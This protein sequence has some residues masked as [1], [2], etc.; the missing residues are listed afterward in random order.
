MGARASSSVDCWPF[1]LFYRFSAADFFLHANDNEEEEYFLINLEVFV[2]AILQKMHRILV[3]MDRGMH[4][5]AYHFSLAACR[6]VYD[7]QATNRA[8]ASIW[9]PFVDN[10]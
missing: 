8:M 9:C 3:K 6:W 10:K 1:L 7:K 4:A 2:P 5:M